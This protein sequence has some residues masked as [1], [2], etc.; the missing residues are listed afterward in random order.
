MGGGKW[1]VESGELR[2]G[3]WGVGSGKWGV[4]VDLATA[5]CWE[6]DETGLSF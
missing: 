1:K 2:S 3:E 4:L 6:I 5:S